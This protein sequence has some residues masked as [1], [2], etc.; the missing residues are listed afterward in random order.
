MKIINYTPHK[1]NYFDEQNVCVASWEPE[2]E[3]VR[4]SELVNPRPNHQLSEEFAICAKLYNEIKGLP[5]SEDGIYL[6]V[7]I[8]VL[9]ANK[10]LDYPRRDLICPD[11]GPDS[12]VRSPEGQ[13]IGVRRFQV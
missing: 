13:I 5:E 4:V 12:V 3:P 8:I 9:N 2:G 11:T 1:V 7:S 10:S 6:I